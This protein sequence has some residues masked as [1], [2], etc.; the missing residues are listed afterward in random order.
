MVAVINVLY[1][2][3]EEEKDFI[4]VLVKHDFVHYV[5]S[6]RFNDS[7]WVQSNC[8]K[9]LYHY[10]KIEKESIISEIKPE[11]LDVHAAG[12][13]VLIVDCKENKDFYTNIQGFI[14]SCFDGSIKFKVS[15]YMELLDMFP[16]QDEKLIE[17]K[18][19]KRS[20]EDTEEDFVSTDYS[21][22][23]QK[24]EE[25]NCIFYQLTKPNTDRPYVI[26]VKN[27]SKHGHKRLFSSMKIFDSWGV[28]KYDTTF[29]V[30]LW[31]YLG[32]CTPADFDALTEEHIEA[33]LYGD[34][35]EPKVWRNNMATVV[36]DYMRKNKSF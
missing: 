31:E 3:N 7:N 36:E 22:D 17:L 35:D 20:L 32:F 23:Y 1:R 5:D 21:F 29:L 24:I 16:A 34:E 30:K 11:D 12:V 13:F 28:S 26:L 4:E 15:E 27:F 19:E 6:T 18:K 2:G 9:G 25:L 33:V 14:L 8:K 10:R